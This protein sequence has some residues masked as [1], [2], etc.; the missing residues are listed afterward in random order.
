[1][2][3]KTLSTKNSLKTAKL[4]TIYRKIRRKKSENS[5][6]VWTYPENFCGNVEKP[7][8]R[9]GLGQKIFLDEQLIFYYNRGSAHK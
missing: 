6:F 8:W 1:M 3:K 4:Y 7:A 5:F 2:R 9:A